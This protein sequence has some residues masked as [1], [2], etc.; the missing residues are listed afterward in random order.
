MTSSC[1]LDTWRMAKDVA[2]AVA[3]RAG[4]E[5]EG[6]LRASEA[7]LLRGTDAA[8]VRRALWARLAGCEYRGVEEVFDSCASGHTSRFDPIGLRARRL[9]AL[10]REVGDRIVVVSDLPS[11]A[12]ASLA[13]RLRVDH[14]VCGRPEVDDGGRLT[15]VF[16]DILMGPSAGAALVRQARRMEV[17]LDRC[18]AYGHSPDDANL[19][20]AAGSGYHLASSGAVTDRAERDED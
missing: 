4:L 15:G 8:S 13:R 3:R 1:L 18:V 9:L 5:V 2:R 19:L 16:P 7:E 17:P 20:A 11:F 6:L 12:A 14:V 10:H